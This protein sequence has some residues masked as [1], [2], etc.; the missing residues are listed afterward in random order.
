MSLTL[1]ITIL[2]IRNLQVLHSVVTLFIYE[3]RVSKSVTHYVNDFDRTV[4]AQ[5]LL[6]LLS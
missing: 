6:V 1:Y 4:Y 3:L 2:I 5:Y